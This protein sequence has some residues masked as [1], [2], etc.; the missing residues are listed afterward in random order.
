MSEDLAQDYLRGFPRFPPTA[1][2]DFSW[3]HASSPD[4]GS[5]HY[6]PAHHR[7]LTSAGLQPLR[8]QQLFKRNGRCNVKQRTMALSMLAVC[9]MLLLTA[10][11]ASSSGG[12]TTTTTANGGGT[13]KKVAILIPGSINDHGYNATGND[14]GTLIK[15]Q[16]GAQVSVVPINDLTT[17]NADFS[18][19]AQKG[20]NLVIGWGGQFQDGATA[21]APQFPKVDFLCVGCTAQNGTN[22]AS[23]N[24]ETQTWEFV[25]GWLLANLS[26]TSTVGLVG[27]QCFAA[28]ALT[29]NGLK[30]GV[31]YA[32]PQ[33]KVLMTYTGDFENP[34]LALQAANS[35]A[36]EGAGAFAGNL[37]NAYYGLYD[38]AK[39]HGNLPVINEWLDSHSL[40]PTVIASSVLKSESQFVLGVAKHVNDGTF[41]GQLY[42]FLLTPQSGPA[43]SKTNLV[44]SALYTQALAIQ[45]QVVSGKIPV[46]ADTSCPK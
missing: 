43:I 34:T 17:Q 4:E 23:V 6:K 36:S 1:E 25:A 7:I 29:M 2:P 10:C 37:N 35:M 46:S 15:Q 26:K 24:Q 39:A 3:H 5:N 32:K 18:A 12:T 8:L 31:A 45:K 22:L 14:A 11:G 44:P 30:Q 41:K 27:A 33:D 40:A 20:Y 16:F 42:N 9:S 21:V 38:A 28:T 13:L 19:F